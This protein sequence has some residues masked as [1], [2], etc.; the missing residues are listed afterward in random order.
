MNYYEVIRQLIVYK[1]K[2]VFNMLVKFQQ[3]QE[4]PPIV[5]PV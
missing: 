3:E 2:S 4:H 1:K 5:I